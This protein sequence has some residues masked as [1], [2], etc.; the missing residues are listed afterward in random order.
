LARV[1]LTVRIFAGYLVL[2]SAA[3]LTVPTFL[4][5]L[6][7]L[8]ATSDVWPRI[9]GMLVL[10]LALYYWDAGRRSDA[11]FVRATLYG[12][13]LVFAGLVVFVVLG[14][15]RPILLLFMLVDLAFVAWSGYELRRAGIGLTL[16]DSTPQSHG[17]SVQEA[18]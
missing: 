15:S 1:N 16:S 13:L 9:I 11:G 4:I 12:R 7:G 18:S 2:V 6:F 5:Q 17:A 14:M 3:L 10:A 8:P